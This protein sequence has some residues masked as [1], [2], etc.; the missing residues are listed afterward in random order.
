V[1]RWLRVSVVLAAAAFVV[2]F[3]VHAVGDDAE[4]A[5]AA[6]PLS[7]ERASALQ[8]D[9]AAKPTTTVRLAPVVELPA[10]SK[11]PRAKVVAREKAEKKARAA[12]AKQKKAE[13]ARKK[14]AAAA[15]KKKEAAARKRAAQAPRKAVA[16]PPRVAA[17]PVPQV[18]PTAPTY[19]PPAP[20]PKSGYVGKDFDSKG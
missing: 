7:A 2:T 12:R 3:R 6:A 17:T 13:A 19:T 8:S 11:E 5:S 4:P 20:K 16:A 15:R 9:T 10:L 18:R 14:K 1:S